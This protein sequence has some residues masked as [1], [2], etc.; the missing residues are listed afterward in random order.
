[1]KNHH[2][3]SERYIRFVLRYRLAALMSV[4]TITLVFGYFLTRLSIRTDF[5]SLYPP[6]H[7][8]IQLYNQYRNMFGTANVLVCAIEVKDG[9]IYTVETIR[10]IDRITQKILT[11]DGCNATQVASITHPKLKN[12]TVNAWGI[13]IT[14]LMHPRVPED[15][16][17]L[18]RLKQAIY[19]N[20]GI[21]GF[22]VS[23]DDSTAAVF[24]G[25][26]EEGIDPLRLYH[27][28]EEIKREE[29]DNHTNIYFTGYP[30]LYANVFYLAPQVYVVLGITFTV[31]ISLL[32]FFFRS[33]QGV[34]LPV[35]SAGVSAI[36]GLGFLSICGYNLDPLILVIPIIITAR[37]LSHTVQTLARYN[38]EFQR[39]KNKD[40]ALVKAYAELLSP[41]TLSVVT[42][43][44]GVLFIAVATIPLMQHLA[45]FCSFWIISIFITV[46]TL[47]PVL[48]S[49]LKPLNVKH[50]TGNGVGRI[51]KGIAH[52]LMKPTMG[53]KR[54]VVIGFI[55]FILV[56]GIPYSLQLKVGDTQAGAALLF[57]EHP[58]NKAFRFFNQKFV[59]GNQLVIIAEGKEQGAIKSREALEAIEDLQ[60]YMETEGGAGGTLTFTNM[61]KRIYRMFHEG[62]PKW[63]V[64]PDDPKHLGQIGF[65]LASCSAPGEMDRWLDNTWSNA[66]ITCFYKDYNNDLIKQS[67]AKAKAFIDAHSSDSDTVTFRLAGGLL[68][69]LAAMNEEVEYSYWASL[70]AVFIVVF[71][72]CVLN[73]RSVAAGLVLII[74][75]AISQILSEVFMLFK[76]IDLNINS[77]PVAAIAVGIGVDYGIYLTSRISEEYRESGNYD[78]A[79]EKS[80]QTTGEAI[81]FTA[82]TLIAGVFFWM[83]IDLKFQAEMGLLLGLLM[84]LNMIAA[85][86]FIPVLIKLFKPKFMVEK[87]N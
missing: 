19:Q 23:P 58:Y 35:I 80:L 25:F 17:D 74:P 1:M 41:S 71:L 54:Y 61:V 9:D 12:V 28:L 16:A 39:I 63:E 68:G 4:V 5:F 43:A 55:A 52:M 70:A 79:I 15:E 37:A 57:P 48:L 69:I 33:W 45:Y 50:S 73:Y 3:L 11:L 60:R 10:K 38:E 82:T 42:D 85:L 13:E 30:A 56:A 6:K 51:Y 14:P 46:P 34:V 67:I 87:F 8:Y 77:L 20:A 2:T 86:I 53:K 18:K 44:V 32:Y 29:T 21:R 84:T 66:T 78:I 76:G 22:Y 49:Y 31:M 47:T 64:I 59:G 65:Q 40:D 26:W 72:L 36:W 7:P 83:F 75:L 81:I 24:A 27:R 62:N